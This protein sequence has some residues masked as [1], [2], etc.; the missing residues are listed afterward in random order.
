[1]P[2][3]SATSSSGTTSP[4]TGCLPPFSPPRSFPYTDDLTRLV[5]AFAIFGIA[6]VA[7]P[8]GALLFASYGDRHGRQ[9]ALVAGIALMALVTAGIG[10]LPGYGSH[11]LAGADSAT[12]ACAPGR[13][14]RSAGSRAGRPRSSWST[15]RPIAAAGTAVGSTPPSASASVPASPPGPPESPRC[16][17]RHCRPGDGVSRSCVALPLGWSG[18]TFGFR[19]EE[20]PDFRSVQRRGA[21]SSSAG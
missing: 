1:M 9:R 2:L 12:R 21:V 18:S 19:L 10:L 8:V 11:R 13:A 15:H 5:A 17:P 3:A 7:R 6:F 14:R 4:C 16:P 20:T